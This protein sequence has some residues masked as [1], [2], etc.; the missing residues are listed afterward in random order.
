MNIGWPW[1]LSSQVQWALDTAGVTQWGPV[2]YEG[3]YIRIRFQ[4]G[5]PW[6]AIIAGVIIALGLAFASWNLYRIVEVGGAGLG[7]GV[8]VVVALIALVAGGV[9]FGDKAKD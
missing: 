5:F 2:T 6:L 7:W 9:R 8:L 1:D 4:K 3:G